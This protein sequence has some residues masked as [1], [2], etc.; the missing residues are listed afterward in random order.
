MEKEGVN[1]CVLE[2]S[3]P[4]PKTLYRCSLSYIIK[5][6]INTNIF[7]RFYFIDKRMLIKNIEC[8]ILACKLCV[9][10]MIFRV[11]FT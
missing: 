10:F 1:L 2:K 4:S 9:M 5:N 7:S 8:I 3:C 11:I 6:C